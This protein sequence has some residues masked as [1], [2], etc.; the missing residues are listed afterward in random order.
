MNRVDIKY[1]GGRSFTVDD[2][3]YLPAGLTRE[4]TLANQMG[5]AP[6]DTAWSIGRVTEE[7]YSD[8]MPFAIS[9]KYPRRNSFSGIARFGP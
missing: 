7:N 6:D 9:E 5:S 3:K 8:V 4:L 1:G 2:G